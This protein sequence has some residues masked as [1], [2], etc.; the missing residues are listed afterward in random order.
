MEM[1]IKTE[2]IRQ[3]NFGDNNQFSY[4]RKQ[5]EIKNILGAAVA[6]LDEYF[7][8]SSTGETYKLCKTSEGN[9][10]DAPNTNIAINKSVLLGLNWGL[11]VYKLS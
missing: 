2:E 7:I 1:D 10:Y 11:M 5:V 4:T 9:W 6:V 3:I 8:T